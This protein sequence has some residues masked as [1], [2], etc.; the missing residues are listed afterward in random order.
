MLVLLSFFL[1]FVICFVL[2]K[3]SSIFI[4]SIK[5]IAEYGV[6]GK[7]ALAGIFAGIMTSIPE[8]FVSIS[9]ALEKEPVVAVGNALGS[10]IA[11]IALV[12]PLIIILSGK[13]INVKKEDFNLRTVFLVLASSILP[14]LLALD[15]SISRVDGLFLITMFFIYSIYIF[16]SKPRLNLRI[17]SFIKKIEYK[18][19]HTRILEPFLIMI[20]STLILIISSDT[21]IRVGNFLSSA[22][23]INVFLIGVFLLGLG[24]SLPELFVGM[25]SLQEGE[26]TIVFGDILG[27]LITNANLAIGIAALLR[28]INFS[29]F[30][31]YW[32]S[33]LAL[34]LSFLIFTIFSFT[35]RKLE[36][37]EAY[38][39]LSFY[40]LFI[41]METLI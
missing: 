27:S 10:N 23:H 26:D 33:I 8:L 4:A 17:K 13:A 28:P 22:M 32:I 40:L 15:G 3:T 34:F 7:F 14:F 20:V 2:Y 37:W 31:E 29:N 41:V 38:I 16:Q 9:A 39:L 6:I 12:V 36:K 5:S 35:K 18:F 1:I 11:D 19:N 25:S 30:N 24:T 21:L